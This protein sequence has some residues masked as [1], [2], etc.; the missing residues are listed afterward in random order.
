MWHLLTV[1]EALRVGEPHELG[2]AVGVL[3]A[4][5]QQPSQPAT[6]RCRV[7]AVRLNGF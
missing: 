7:Y 4:V 5:V 1:V 2:V 6:L 3:P